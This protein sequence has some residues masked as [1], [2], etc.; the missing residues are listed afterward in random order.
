[1]LLNIIFTFCFSTFRP[2]GNDATEVST[3][4][5]VRYVNSTGRLLSK[6]LISDYCFD[7]IFEIFSKIFICF[8]S[9]LGTYESDVACS[10]RTTVLVRQHLPT[11]CPQMTTNWIKIVNISEVILWKIIIGRK[12]E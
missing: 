12:Y 7:K 11:L 6:N 3:L 4:L 1:M 8:F 2:S 5:L 10:C 9:E